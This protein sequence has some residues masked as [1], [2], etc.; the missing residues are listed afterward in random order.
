MTPLPLVHEASFF[1]HA[2]IVFSAPV[3]PRARLSPSPFVGS[4]CFW[5]VGLKTLLHLLSTSHLFLTPSYLVGVPDSAL[6]RVDWRGCLGPFKSRLFSS[7]NRLGPGRFFETC[8][9]AVADERKGF[10]G[11]DFLFLRSA[12]SRFLASS[13]LGLVVDARGTDRFFPF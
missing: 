13:V 8:R 4:R 6:G 10:R 5:A 2:S 1:I 11:D 12:C 3:V 9:E 7:P